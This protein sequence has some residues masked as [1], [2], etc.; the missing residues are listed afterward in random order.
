MTRYRRRDP[1][2]LKGQFEVEK[3]AE[4]ARRQALPSRNLRRR[5][6]CVQIHGLGGSSDESNGLMPD[7][8]IRPI[9]PT[10]GLCRVGCYGARYQG[11]S[12]HGEFC[13]WFLF[14]QVCASRHGSQTGPTIDADAPRTNS[15]SSDSSSRESRT[16]VHQSSLSKQNSTLDTR[17]SISFGKAPLKSKDR[18]AITS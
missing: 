13:F 11:R 7:I 12:E 1:P 18:A 4:P 15:G 3:S 6:A 10:S 14:C 8:G 16:V 5:T 9:M 17:R 2:N